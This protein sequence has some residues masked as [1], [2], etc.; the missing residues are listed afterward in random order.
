MIF[1]AKKVPAM[2]TLAES[3]E[4]TSRHYYVSVLPQTKELLYYPISIGRFDCKPCYETERSSFYSYLLIVM[5]R[6]ELRYR[7]RKGHGVARAGQVLLLDCNVPHSYGAQGACSFSYIHFGGAQTDAICESIE[8]QKG[9]LLTLPDVSML[10]STLESIM[11][12][13][14]DSKRLDEAATSAKIYGML[15]HLLSASSAISR[16]TTGVS[17]LDQVMDFVQSHLHEKL[18]VERIAEHAGYSP[19]YLSRLF[20]HENDMSLYQ[21][22]LRCRL[23]R[24]QYLINT[25]RLSIEEIAS[26]TG[27]PSAANF[28][29]AFRRETGLSPSE[30]RKR[31]F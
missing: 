16:G 22:V 28:S 23:E 17:M 6:G 1:D 21:F 25:T 29:Q 20:T 12:A 27:F 30:Y 5:H 19:G 7:N 13:L 2:P 14:D 11:D 31:S 10:V 4:A 8:R 9:L 15:M 18:T 3:L 24:A 26:Q